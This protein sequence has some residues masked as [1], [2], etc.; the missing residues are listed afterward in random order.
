VLFRIS[1]AAVWF[2][3][4]SAK[5]SKNQRKK[6]SRREVKENKQNQNSARTTNGFHMGALV[7]AVGVE[8]CRLEGSVRWEADKSVDRGTSL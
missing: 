5:A 1:T 3:F 7:Q 6:H 2:A 4:N 8:R